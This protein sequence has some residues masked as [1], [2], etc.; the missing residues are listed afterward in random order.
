MYI[1]YFYIFWWY[2]EGLGGIYD[3]YVRNAMPWSHQPVDDSRCSD[4]GDD[5]GHIVNGNSRIQQMELR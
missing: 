4:G 2:L 3:N 5:L 1:Q